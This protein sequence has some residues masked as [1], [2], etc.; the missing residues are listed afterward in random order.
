LVHPDPGLDVRD[1]P[2]GW[3]W[4]ERSLCAFCADSETGVEN[5]LVRNLQV[6]LLRRRW[7][8]RALRVFFNR[9]MGPIRDL[10]PESDRFPGLASPRVQIAAS[11]E[12]AEQ[13]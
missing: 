6:G 4:Q 12:H 3:A 10:N 8:D 11:D 7:L 5:G 2:S 1:I 9:L 13:T